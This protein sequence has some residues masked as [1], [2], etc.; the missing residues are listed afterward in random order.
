MKASLLS[1]LQR[2][3]TFENLEEDF[4][5]FISSEDYKTCVKVEEKIITWYLLT[6]NIFVPFF[7][8]V[9][10]LILCHFT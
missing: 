7:Y 6:M 2:I 8:M 9:R 10:L 4:K 3:Y 1:K 5:N